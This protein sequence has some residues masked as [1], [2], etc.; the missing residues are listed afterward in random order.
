M[1]KS[2]VCI[3][4]HDIRDCGA[5]CLASI[6]GYYGTHIPIA[7]IRQFCHT[8]TRGTNVL[9]MVQGLQQMGFNAKGV[10]GAI[11]AIPQIP[12]PAIAHVVLKEQLQH[13]VVIYQV[14]K[15]KITV[16]DP[17]LGK[18][19]KYTFEAFQ[20]IWTGVL[21]LMEPNEY[22]EQKN[23]KI[24][25]YK[26]FWNLIRPHRS[27][28]VQALVGAAVYTLLGLSTSFYIEKITDYVLVDGNLRLLNLLSIGML[29]IL[30]FQLLIGTLKSVMVLQTGQRIDKYLI[31]G[32]YKHL[33]SLPQR[34][35][36]TMKVGEIISRVNDAVKIRAFINDVAI[37]AV[38]NVLI[39]VFSFALM[40]TYFWKLALIMLLVI[41]F[42]LGVYWLSNKLNKKVERRMMEEGAELESHLVESLNSVKTIKQFGIETYFNSGTDN[43]F[44]HVLKTIYASVM[45]GLFSSTSGELLSRLFTIILLWVGSYYVIERTITPGELLSFYALIGYFTGPVTQLIGMNKT[46]QNA[47]IAADRLFEIM[48]LEREESE[49]KLQLTSDLVGDIVF[50]N[51][52][53]SYGSRVE[54]FRNFSCRIQQSKMTAVIGESGSGKTTLG[55]LI[56]QL[57]PLQEG[58]ISIGQYDL[59]Y[60]SKSSLRERIAIVP[61][62]IDLFSGNIVSNIAVGEDIP[63]FQRLLQVVNELDMM[64]FIEKLPAGFETQLGENGSMLSGGQRQRIAIARALYR[65][66]DIL[67]LDEATSAL[68]TSTEQV[69]QRAFRRFKDS[70]K[71]MIVIAHRLSTIAEADTIMV[72]KDGVLIEQGEHNQLL[73][74]ESAYKDMWKKQSIVL[75]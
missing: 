41:P 14:E 47:L 54:V 49:E 37:Q 7:K 65:N 19:E 11:D 62:Q 40:F 59:N 12:L 57:Y 21:I 68:D 67:I 48:D 66:P 2:P 13:Y 26:R 27:V 56:Q 69:I 4:Q 29:V 9:G 5:A 60:I 16:M 6:A 46:L 36:D 10:K 45:N 32:Y 38:V 55:A 18:V 71:T 39:V 1:K 51:V 53:F 73:A 15:D 75:N 3:K 22:F 35:F 23:E 43:R 70:G 42:Y 74:Q 24:D 17:G 20:K 63:N 33:L 25:V 50:D 8:D 64:S 31:L 30:I 34:F 72:L 44:S 28:I 61:Q 52:R 58:K